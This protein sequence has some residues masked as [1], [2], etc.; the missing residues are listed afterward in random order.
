VLSFDVS[1][2]GYRLNPG[3]HG[4]VSPVLEWKVRPIEETGRGASIEV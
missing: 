4:V 1:E 2:V 3:R